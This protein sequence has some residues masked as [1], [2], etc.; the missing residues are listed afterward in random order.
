VERD[1]R[2]ACPISLALEAVGDR[3]SLLVLRDLILRGKSRYQELCN[4][5]ERIATNILAGRLAR[6]ERQGRCIS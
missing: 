1:P 2:S 6:L 3:W 4:S 5:E